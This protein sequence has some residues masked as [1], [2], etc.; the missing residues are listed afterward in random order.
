MSRK[1]AA[2]LK[3]NSDPKWVTM[4]E[5]NGA[6]T[7]DGRKPSV[8]LAIGPLL[9]REVDLDELLEQIVD[10]I[11]AALHADRGTI[12]LVDP[13]TGELFSKAAHLPELKQIRLQFGQ[14]IA[15]TVAATGAAVNLASAAED[16]RFFQ[17]IDRQTG[18]RTRSILAAPLRDREGKVIGVVQVLNA[19]R[20]AFSD[21]D[22][23]SLKRLCAEAA[24]AIETTSLYPQVR[25]RDRRTRNLPVRYRYNRIV[26][27]S[28]AMQAVYELTRKAAA[29]D[30]TVLLRGESGTGKELIAR[31]IH[32]NSSRRD[33]PFVKLDCT[34]IPATLMENE[35]F[36]HERGAYTGAESRAVGKCELAQGGTLF[37]DEL[38]E[39]PIGLQSKLLRFIQDREFERVGGTRTHSADVRVVAATHR[40]LEGMVG[41]GQFREDL[42]YRVKVVQMLLPP[43]HERGPEDI[44][45]LA[46]HF[47]DGY[48]RKHRKPELYFTPAALDRLVQHRWPGNIRELENCVESAVVLCE[49]A[50]I[51]P[52]HLALPAAPQN[53]PPSSWRPRPLMAVEREHILRTLEGT[54]G[55]RTRAAAL[56]G[57][58]RNTLVRKLKEFGLE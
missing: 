27:E 32:Y 36:G 29:T 8:L 7:P 47:L 58:G 49:G 14:G 56:L 23:E 22:E 41:R 6:S 20:G 53:G 42:Y 19:A 46:D 13:D 25:P 30:A 26:G 34:T 15:G 17:E 54:A 24:L 35:L 28:Q 38:G 52:A 40:D 5:T 18:Y 31:A 11:V 2:V 12:Y 48:R 21:S 3:W 44:V 45:R 51:E 1:R 10:K 4:A 50:G 33:G 43:L 57:I 55:N 37:I 16:R 9:Q 39:L